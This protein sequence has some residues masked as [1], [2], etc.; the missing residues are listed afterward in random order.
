M[1]ARAK[2]K[3]L[4]RSDRT[5]FMEQC[6]SVIVDEGSDEDTAR[7]IC[8]ILWD[9]EDID[10]GELS[11]TTVRK[12]HADADN[13]SMEFILS[14]ATP[15]RYGDII[16]PAG[17]DL[18]NFNRNPIAL[19]NHNSDFPIGSWEK[20][21]VVDGKLRGHLTMAPAGTSPRIDEL[22]NLIEAGI[23]RAV[24][25]GFRPI[26]RTYI[27]GSNGGIRYLKSELIETS[28]VS[29]PANPNALAVAKSMNVSRE[30]LDMVFAKHGTEDRT[31][32]R[33]IPNGGHAS[34]TPNG[35]TN[36]MNIA[37]RIVEA[38]NRINGLRD[39]LNA[40][41]EGI[42]DANVTDE[43]T[44]LT[45][46]LTTQ[47]ETQEKALA[48]LQRAEASI[49]KSATVTRPNGGG[50]LDI[51]RTGNGGRLFATVE[52]KKIQPLDLLFKAIATDIKHFGEGR[53][54]PILEVLKENYGD[55]D[56]GESVRTVMARM[57]TKAASIPA[58]TT[59]SGWADTLVQTVIG[60]FIESLMPFSIY[61]ALRAKGGTFTFGRNGTISLPA[62]TTSTT[63]A[64]AFVAQ[65]APIPVRQGAFT[66][67]TLTPKKMGVITTMTR[68][69]TEHST[70][71][72][73]AILRQAMMEDTAV[74]ID[75][76]LLDATAASAT[77]P[78]GLKNGQ[79]KVTATAGGAVPA[80][81]IGDLRGLYAALITATQGNI[82]NPAWIMNPGDVLAA[83][84]IQ[85]TTGDTPFREEISRGTLLGFPILQS[86]TGLS[87]MMAIIDAADFMTATGDTPQFSVSDQAVL[88][89]EDTS[90][91]ALSTAGTPNV[92]AAPIRSLWQTDSMA[93]RMILDINWAK[94][95]AGIFQWTDT[96]TWN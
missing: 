39:Q 76:I 72:I 57:V 7:D 77:R 96:M 83:S 82:R 65:G 50:D 56:L 1:N 86:T 42:D 52:R 41:V 36:T 45:E 18:K 91:A 10:L 25:V 84:L 49:A 79:T 67:I 37:Q 95:R 78:A 20:L 12:T 68:E 93:I 74:A 55:N 59:T 2:I 38:Q 27:E 53:K 23:L 40:H 92:V 48:A 62:R 66:P 6:I 71:Q 47:I 63:V 19:F 5:D 26:E 35:K 64:G 24:S 17:W 21:K 34:K 9:D 3:T 61:P 29:V 30:T 28:L 15:D 73:E 51:T 32:E 33:S 14:D 44:A 75:T 13:K 89:M 31:R 85:T 8:E 94:R 81:L 88:H 90:P 69:I 80:A 43:Q 11:M 60:D 58:D 46:T 54:R 16:E 22:R 4:K 70:P 87:D